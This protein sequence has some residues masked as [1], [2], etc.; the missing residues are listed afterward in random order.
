MQRLGETINAD[1]DNLFC[2]PPGTAAGSIE[3]KGHE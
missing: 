2:Q 1:S 3:Y